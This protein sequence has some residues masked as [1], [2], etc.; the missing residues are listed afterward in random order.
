MGAV[1]AGAPLGRSLGADLG[2]VG[3]LAPPPPTATPLAGKCAQR[4]GSPARRLPAAMARGAGLPLLLCCLGPLLCGAAAPG[5]PPGRAVSDLSRQGRRQGR[6]QG[7]GRPK[8]P[9]KNK[10]KK[11]AIAICSGKSAGGPSLPAGV[12]DP[13]PNCRQTAGPAP[14]SG[15]AAPSTCLVSWCLEPA[16]TGGWSLPLVGQDYLEILSSWYCSFGKC[17]E[18]GDCRIANNI[19]GLELDLNRRLHGQHL[20]KDVILKAVQGFLETPQPEKALALS[21][22]GWS[23]T[24]KNFVARMI[25]DHLYRDGLKSECVK[26]FISLFHFPHP[27]YVDLY[28][29]QLKK[30]ISETV[31][32]CKQSLFIFDEAEKLHSGLLDAIKPYVDHYDSIDE[33]DY[34]RSIFLFLSNIGGNIISQVTLDF[35]RAGRAREEITMEYLEQ[36]LRLELLESTDGGFAHSHLIEENLIDFFVPF[37]PLENCHVKLCV[38]DAFLARSLPYTEEVLDEVVRMMVFI[39]EEKLFSAQGCKSVSHRINYFLP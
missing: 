14:L 36:H 7:F 24:G 2:R 9:N 1:A 4:W 25:A 29:V 11:A 35:W 30:Q 31:Q 26:V 17:C 27:K 22:H 10:T 34:R 12:R 15:V 21:F 20:A 6:L 23:G 39:P 3:E 13:L 32:L 37:L 5:V 38:R 18:T 28:K 8:Q 33:V 16:L 19:T